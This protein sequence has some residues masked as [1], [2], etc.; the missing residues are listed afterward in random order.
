LEL[1][2]ILDMLP[3]GFLK[4]PDITKIGIKPEEPYQLGSIGNL[5]SSKFKSVC[6]LLFSTKSID[7]EAFSTILEGHRLQGI[8]EDLEK[9]ELADFCRHISILNKSQIGWEFVD[10]FELKLNKSFTPRWKL[11]NLDFDKSFRQIYL[12]SI[13]WKV[14]SNLINQLEEFINK[15]EE[16]IGYKFE[17]TIEPN[18]REKSN[19]SF[20]EL[21]ILF[22]ALIEIQSKFDATIGKNKFIQLINKIK[23]LFQENYNLSTFTIHQQL[24]L[25]FLYLKS[26]MKLSPSAL[27]ESQSIIENLWSTIRKLPEDEFNSFRWI[28]GALYSRLSYN[29]FNSTTNFV[30]RRELLS[31]LLKD[32]LKPV[33]LD[34]T[35][36]SKILISSRPH[37]LVFKFLIEGY[38]NL[39]I[40]LD[41]HMNELPDVDLKKE[42]GQLN[43]KISYFIYNSIWEYFR[44]Y[45]KIEKLALGELHKINKI[46]TDARMTNVI[47]YD[48]FDAL[49]PSIKLIL[50]GDHTISIEE[51]NYLIQLLGIV[52]EA[53]YGNTFKKLILLEM[54]L[55]FDLYPFQENC[56]KIHKDSLNKDSL[57]Q[58]EYF[59]DF[60]IT[61]IGEAFGYLNDIFV[62]TNTIKIHE[63][64]IVLYFLSEWL[65]LLLSVEDIA[66]ESIIILSPLISICFMQIARGFF[67]TNQLEKAYLIYYNNH[68]FIEVINGHEIDGMSIGL[69][70]HKKKSSEVYEKFEELIKEWDIGELISDDYI[71]RISTNIELKINEQ[72]LN[73]SNQSFSLTGMLDDEIVLGYLDMIANLEDFLASIKSASLSEIQNIISA[74]EVF[75]TPKRSNKLM[76]NIGRI[77]KLSNI[78][79]LPFPLINNIYPYAVALNLYPIEIDLPELSNFS[80]LYDSYKK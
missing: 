70:A 13:N 74:A 33:E 12:T 71:K 80:K 72:R 47:K 56:D 23:Y 16:L 25:K 2:A 26:Y 27:E 10:Y 79:G 54:Q 55:I 49:I 28:F 64:E 32:F 3:S 9:D 76:E 4:L 21:S 24:S 53:C 46:I 14:E 51:R 52:G 22:E 17:M 73:I 43:L 78:E 30:A 75:K 41:E 77:L 48:I 44:E 6:N 11:P 15:Y 45:Y 5:H 36:W 60:I 58:S 39:V 62:K 37:P 35:D 8:L 42:L 68:Y 50:Y 7:K 18:V 1:S 38:K 29:L 19:W 34:L 65:H 57:I 40:M 20:R 63:Y 61:K 67:E 66:F 69:G 59:E 31:D